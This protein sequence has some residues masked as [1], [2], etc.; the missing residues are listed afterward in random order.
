MDGNVATSSKPAAVTRPIGRRLALVSLAIGLLC[1]MLITALQV[2]T[3]YRENRALLLAK[4][5]DIENG[6]RAS[7]ED[8][9]WTVD[10][11]RVENLVEGIAAIEGVAEVQVDT[12][13][14]E[15]IQ[16]GQL[17]GPALAEKRMPL[18]REF[19]AGAAPIALGELQVK[20]SDAE[21]RAGLVAES[22]RTLGSVSLALVASALLL[23]LL[24]RRW[25]TRHLEQMAD[26][27]AR[28]NL[29]S[30]GEP[31]KL[32]RDE[33]PDELGSV[34]Q[35]VNQ[36]Q[37]RIGQLIAI[38]RQ[39]AQQLAAHRDQLEQQ[40]AERTQELSQKSQLLARQADELRV[41]NRDLEAYA[42]TVAH[43]LKIPLTTVVGLSGLLTQMRD[44]M[45][46]QQ[47]GES[48]HTIH[49]TSRKMAEIIDALLTLASLRS[50]RPVYP[51]SLDTG[52]ILSECLARLQPMIEQN[53]ARIVQQANWPSAIG[54]ADWIEAVWTNYI[55]NAIK[56][57]GKPARIELGAETRENGR[58]RFFVRDHGPGIAR[59]N[60]SRLFQAFSRL[61]PGSAEGHGI[62]LSIVARILN[63]LGG[64]AGAEPAEGGGSLFWFE[65]PAAP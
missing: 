33:A 40:V 7:L 12:P 2:Q 20:L 65:L 39:Q 43:D 17:D 18:A 10:L 50:D 28:I 59:E 21:L 23:A 30:I 26:Y 42:H 1:A 48:L 8:A 55:S 37:S 62:G 38:E 53:N 31:L 15:H 27:A 60:Y 5:A 61:D 34:V 57:G 47:L 56:Y 24:F 25:V 35:A 52:K 49:R 63:K 51:E 9:L 3:R 36:M 64:E 16:R 11:A 58:V 13:Q 46:E 44:K 32:A 6:Y 45:S 14:G 29:E 41:Q 19:G 22:L 4:M 54:R